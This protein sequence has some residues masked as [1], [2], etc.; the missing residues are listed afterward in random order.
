VPVANKRKSMTTTDLE[1]EKHCIVLGGLDGAS[2][3]QNLRALKSNL[4]QLETFVADLSDAL[5]VAPGPIVSLGYE[6]DKDAV[7]IDH[8]EKRLREAI[9]QIIDLLAMTR[10]ARVVLDGG[11]VPAPT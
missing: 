1:T 4:A 10:S 3:V 5:D 9:S 8:L 11:R 2:F 7:L 6:V